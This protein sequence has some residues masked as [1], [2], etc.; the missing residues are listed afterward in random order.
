LAAMHITASPVRG[1][2]RATDNHRPQRFRASTPPA[3]NQVAR[4]T[5]P[6]GMAAHAGGAG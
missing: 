1:R 3:A 6:S 4:S 5:M 2:A